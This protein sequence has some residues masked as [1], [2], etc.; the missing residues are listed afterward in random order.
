MPTI[1][2]APHV[3][4]TGSKKDDPGCDLMSA[5]FASRIHS[6]VPGSTYI[7]STTFRSELD[8]NR[9]Q[10]RGR[11]PMRKKLSQTLEKHKDTNLTVYDI[12]TFTSGKDFG[13]SYTP[14]V[15]LLDTQF[16]PSAKSMV[17]KLQ[18][19]GLKVALL[20][21]T[22]ENDI[23]QETKSFGGKG[24]LLEMP[25]SLSSKKLQLVANAIR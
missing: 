19:Q 16:S 24:Y 2:T 20:R 4:Q 11:T 5:K 7:P 10:S 21:G 13:L 6:S 22:I 18:R 25:D 3:C 23:Q 12:H 15:I 14:D 1:F 17:A 9:I 8:N